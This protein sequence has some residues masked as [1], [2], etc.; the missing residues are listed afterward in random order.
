[1]P[2]TRVEK[3]QIIVDLGDRPHRRAWVVTP[4]LLVD[5]Y[6]GGETFDEIHIR[7][8]HLSEELARVG[9]QRL[10]VASLPFRVDRVEGE[11]ALP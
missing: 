3:P 2:D 9:G 11:R 1:M 4:R 7:L 8:L 5:R 10:H 6:R